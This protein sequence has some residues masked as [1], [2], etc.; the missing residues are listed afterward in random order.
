[1]L[2]SSDRTDGNGEN[3]PGD[4]RLPT[5]EKGSFTHILLGDYTVI[6][7]AINAMGVLGYCDRTKWM[8]PVPTGRPGRYISL[9]TRRT[10]SP[11]EP[12]L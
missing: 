6:M 5:F 4:F 3:D 2:N 12:S 1:M 8:K 7:T 9:M 11:G 10:L